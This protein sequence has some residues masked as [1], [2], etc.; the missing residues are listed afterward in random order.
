MSMRVMNGTR[1]IF[2]RFYRYHRNS[3]ND[4]RRDRYR[5][6]VDDLNSLMTGIC[7]E[8]QKEMDQ[9]KNF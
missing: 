4:E 5:L 2:Q 1:N 8:I 6:Y 9:Q 7:F 3:G